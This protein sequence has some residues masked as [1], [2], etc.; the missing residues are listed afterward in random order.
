VAISLVRLNSVVYNSKS[1]TVALGPGQA[2]DR[3]YK[4]L[5]EYGVNVLGGRIVGVGVGGFVLGGG[6]FYFSGRSK[7]SMTCDVL[8]GILGCQIGQIILLRVSHGSQLTQMVSSHGMAIDTVTQFELVL[9]NGT[10]TEVSTTSAPDI[11]FGLKVRGSYS[12]S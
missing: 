4:E 11:F 6:Q 10:I 7:M 5:E 9:P 12:A 1:N 8:Q 3:V 2:W